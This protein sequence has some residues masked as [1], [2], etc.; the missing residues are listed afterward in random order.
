[1]KALQGQPLL[2]TAIKMSIDKLKAASKDDYTVLVALCMLNTAKI[3]SGLIENSYSQLTRGAMG[4]FG[5]IQDVALISSSGD[6][7]YKIH[8]Y[9]RDVVLLSADKETLSKA[10]TLNAQVFLSLFPEKVEDCVE[11]FGKRPELVAHLKKLIAHMDKMDSEVAFGLG[12]REFYY[13]YYVERD[14]EFAKK[15]SDVLKS[16]LDHGKVRNKL[17]H[18]TFLNANSFLTFREQGV[19]AA[20]NESLQA[21]EILK[22]LS[23]KDARHEMLMLLANNLSSYYYWQGNISEAEKCIDEAEKLSEGMPYSMATC[24][25]DFLRFLF[26]TDRG[27]FETAKK[28]LDPL[29]TLAA[30]DTNFQKVS[31]HYLKSLKACSLIKM[32]DASGAKTISMDAYKEAVQSSSGHEDTDIVGRTLIY[33]SFSQ[34]ATGDVMEAETSA[35]RAIKIFDRELTGTHKNRRQAL[36][37][38]ALGDAYMGQ[39]RYADAVKEYR[40]A[41][42]IYNKTCTHLS[43]DD[44]SELYHKMVIAYIAQKDRIN[45]RRYAIKHQ[46]SFPIDHPRF[47]DIRNREDAAA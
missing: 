16:S 12:L 38:T 23:L 21:K 43:F 13:V 17:L 9:V 14:Y 3:E 24:S 26:K 31:G 36:S 30:N 22:N 18:A 41:E 15:L 39:K 25:I 33:L 10:A 2:S 34:S 47:I 35:K 46:K 27:D 6:K 28:H 5:K 45:V 7:A 1:E 44:M 11:V 32:G 20:I 42:D 4:G 19:E 29:F 40:Y 8:D 37:H